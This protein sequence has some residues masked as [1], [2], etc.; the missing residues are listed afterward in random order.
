[1]ITVVKAS[2]ITSPAKTLW[3]SWVVSGMIAAFTIDS[4]YLINSGIAAATQ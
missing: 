4:K 3:H 1:V 2:A